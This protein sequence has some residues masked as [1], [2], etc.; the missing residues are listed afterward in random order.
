MR[1]LWLAAL[2]AGAGCM[3]EEFM[4]DGG[5]GEGPGD[6][7][8][9]FVRVL[10]P[11]PGDSVP[12]PVTIELEAG[13]GVERLWIDC[14]GL[15]LPDDFVSARSGIRTC[16][17]SLPGV[18]RTL[19][20]PG[21]DGF[22]FEVASAPVKFT[23]TPGRCGLADQPGFN[24]YTV[25]ALS[26]WGRYPRDGTRGYCWAG[27]GHACSGKWGM[28]HDGK[29]GGAALFPGGD[30]CY[31]SGHTLEILLRAFRLWQAE[32]GA[33][34]RE[35]YC[36]EGGML[37]VEDLALGPFYQLWQGYGLSQDASAADALEWAGIG[38]GIAPESWDEA[39][40]GDFVN[41]WRTTGSGHSAIF[42]AWVFGVSG[43]RIGLRYYGCNARGDSCP[44]PGD[45]GNMPGMSGPS[46]RT[47]YFDGFGG[48]VMPGLL[49]L[50]RPAL[51]Q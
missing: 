1:L 10:A 42:V 17:F 22:G 2:W 8:R 18:E 38:A 36:T 31:C 9:P 11:Q 39:L 23:P 45:P 50:A 7:K 29:Y 19:K 3:H 33:D 16:L 24:R 20:I 5:A 46:F 28:L 35:L 13:G 44:D 25:A 26:D 41:F 14:D 12:N 4:H 51:P 15:P 6:A 30:D 37:A 32:S 34:A 21:L 48:A 49:S 40:T 47:E 43:E 27:Y